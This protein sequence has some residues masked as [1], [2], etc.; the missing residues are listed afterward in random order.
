MQCLHVSIVQ[1]QPQSLQQSLITI[2]ALTGI[3][4]KLSQTLNGYSAQLGSDWRLRGSYSGLTSQWRLRGSYCGL[5]SQWRL[6]GAIV[7]ITSQ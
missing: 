2:I 1:R 5:T 3:V 7:A 4:T 6:R